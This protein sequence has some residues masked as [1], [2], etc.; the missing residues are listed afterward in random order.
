MNGHSVLP[1]VKKKVGGLLK[2]N[3]DNYSASWKFLVEMFPRTLTVCRAMSLE[4]GNIAPYK[5]RPDGALFCFMRWD[6]W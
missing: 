1:M 2:R 5:A 6:P 4:V 3:G